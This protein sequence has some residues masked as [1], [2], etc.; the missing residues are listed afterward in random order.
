MVTRDE[1]ADLATAGGSTSQ[2]IQDSEDDLALGAA[3][4]ADGLIER[5]LGDDDDAVDLFAIYLA[6]IALKRIPAAIPT[7]PDGHAA[8]W[9]DHWKV[10]FDSP[11]DRTAKLA[12]FKANATVLDTHL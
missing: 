7:N 8:Y 6:R 2:R 11:A 3:W 4:P 9:A 1:I 5:L 12:Q 10:I